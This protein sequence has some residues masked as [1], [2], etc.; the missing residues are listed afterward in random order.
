MEAGK[1][2]VVRIALVI[3]KEEVIYIYYEK[4]FLIILIAICI[5]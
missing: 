1:V 2:S 5:D 3:P 4:G